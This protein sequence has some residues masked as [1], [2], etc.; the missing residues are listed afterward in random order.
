MLSPGWISLLP[1]EVVVKFLGV[2]GGF[3]W[4][5]DLGVVDGGGDVVHEAEGGQDL[6]RLVPERFWRSQA[7][8]GAV[9]MMVRCASIGSLVW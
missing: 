3:G 6:F 1:C 5:G 7:I 8:A 2:G 9:N 4:D